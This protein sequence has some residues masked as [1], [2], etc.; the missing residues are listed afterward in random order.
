VLVHAGIPDG[1][2]ACLGAWETLLKGG[3]VYWEWLHFPRGA[4]N[5]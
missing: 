1:G 2:G 3:A 4:A 5:L